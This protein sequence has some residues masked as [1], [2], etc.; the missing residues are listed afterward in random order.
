[1]KNFILF[2]LFGL[3]PFTAL[4]QMDALSTN[5]N[6]V[7]TNLRA[8]LISKQFSFTE[9]A[10]VDKHGNVFFTDQP[11]DKIWEYDVNG[12]LSVFMDKAG[13]ANGTYFDKKGNLLVCADEHNQLWLIHPDKKIDTLLTNYNGHRLNGPN[14]V[15]MD[16]K[17]GIYFT[18][19]YYQRPYWSRTTTDM[20]GQ[21][22]FYLPKGKKEAITVADDLRQPNGIVGIPDGKYL[23]VADIKANKTYRYQT[24]PDGTLTDKQLVIT[25]GSDGMTL[26]EHGNIYLTGKG[27]TVYN[28]AGKK[29]AHIDIPEPWTANLC[30]A[31]KNR[32]D[33]FITASTAIYIIRMKVKG[34]E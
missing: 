5:D 3:T 26:D 9:G 31:G 4:C 11:N 12:K 17:G 21:Y 27:V 15:W 1:M 7:D 22:V 2:L 23:Y 6:V 13:R 24:T 8:T 25:Q 34:V 20:P 28:P 10:S 33:L 18:D 19:P 32:K 16:T 30:F 29:I 14:D